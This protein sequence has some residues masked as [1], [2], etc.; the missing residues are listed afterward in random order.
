MH[1][2]LA[3]SLVSI[4]YSHALSTLPQPIA[5]NWCLNTSHCQ[6]HQSDWVCY[7]WRCRPHMKRSLEEE[8]LV[9]YACPQSRSALLTLLGS[10]SSHVRNVR[11]TRSALECLASHTAAKMASATLLLGS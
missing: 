10:S 9:S 11:S 2:K 6:G 7:N 3:A 8:S 4:S 1:T 5:L